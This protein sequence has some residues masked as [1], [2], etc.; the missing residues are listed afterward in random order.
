M[1]G[2]TALLFTFIHWRKEMAAQ[3]I[4][5]HRILVTEAYWAA[6]YE[7]TTEW[8]TTGR[9]VPS[10]A[11]EKGNG[12]PRGILAWGIPGTGG[13]WWAAVWGCKE[14]VRLKRLSRKSKISTSAWP[15]CSLSWSGNLH[16][17]DD[18]WSS[19]HFWHWR[20]YYVLS[21]ENTYF[22]VLMV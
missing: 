10:C 22:K 17:T 7:T 21:W 12:S 15:L 14:S 13:A 9:L 4:F 19:V 5:C 8:D 16:F 11:L 2:L 20:P 6:V 18:K 1:A 3:Q